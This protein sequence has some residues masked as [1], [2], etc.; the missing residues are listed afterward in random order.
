MLK[1]S[2]LTLTCYP[3]WCDLVDP[4]INQHTYQLIMHDLPLRQW[5][6]QDEL[7]YIDAFTSEPRPTQ[8]S[9]ALHMYSL[10]EHLHYVLYDM[11]ST[12]FKCTWIPVKVHYKNPQF[13]FQSILAESVPAQYPEGLK[14]KTFKE[15]VFKKLLVWN[16]T[17]SFSIS[18]I[19]IL[20]W[21]QTSV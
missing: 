3:S 11:F 20:I 17:M 21:F 13:F 7:T 16:V 5:P 4:Q 9:L 19:F 15:F 18:L 6:V 1:I 2:V 14:I 10:P 8:L 12:P